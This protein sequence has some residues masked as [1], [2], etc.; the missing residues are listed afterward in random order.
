MRPNTDSFATDT[1]EPLLRLDNGHIADPNTRG[2]SVSLRTPHSHS[3]MSVGTRSLIRLCADSGSSHGT[4]PTD[5]VIR[6]FRHSLHMLTR[7]A[8]DPLVLH[9]DAGTFLSDLRETLHLTESA[10]RQIE[11]PTQPESAEGQGEAILTLAGLVEDRMDR[12]FDRVERLT[13]LRQSLF[14]LCAI[15]EAV[16]KGQLP[17]VHDIE[18]LTTTLVD[19]TLQDESTVTLLDPDSPGT[20]LRVAAHSINVAQVVVRL[21]SLVPVWSSELPLA[22]G[23]SLLMDLG[24]LRMPEELL[25]S[26]ELLSA[27]QRALLRKHPDHSATI[28]RQIKWCD[29]R[30]VD[31]VRQHHERLDGS[32]YPNHDRGNAVGPVARLLAVADTYVGI[33]SPRPHRPALSSRQALVEI[34]RAAVEGR[35]DPAWT[36]RLAEIETQWLRIPTIP[37]P[38]SSAPACSAR[39]A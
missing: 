19:V 33:Q 3:A 20:T 22:V 8:R 12:L 38:P 36:C 27:P 1:N 29:E 21:A 4:R 13:A 18:E 6:R 25:D 26:H 7:L 23:A 17:R 35:L 37:Q 32:G 39:A 9:A 2:D 30:W 34:D 5:R 31:A 24:M 28:V 10:L 15:V 16:P 11:T 14:R